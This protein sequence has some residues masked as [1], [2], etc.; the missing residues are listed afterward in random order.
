MDAE[1]LGDSIDANAL[2]HN[3]DSKIGGIRVGMNQAL[4]PD[5]AS[6]HPLVLS[7]EEDQP[8]CDPSVRLEP[9]QALTVMNGYESILISNQIKE[10]RKLII[11]RVNHGLVM[12]SKNAV[13][14]LRMDKCGNVDAVK[15]LDLLDNN[16]LFEK[17]EML[18]HGLALDKNYIY[19]ATTNNIYQFP[20]S[21]GQHSPLENGRKVV[22]NINPGNKDAMPDV[23][24]D[25]FGHAF[26]PRSGILNLEPESISK[27]DQSNAIIKKFN[28]RNI[29]ENGFEYEKDGLV[30]AYGTNS[31]GSMAFDAQARLWGI[32]LPFDTIQ[33]SD[34]G[35][36]ISQHGPAEEI[37]LYG[38]S[39]GHYGFPYCFT[40]Y[41]LSSYTAQSGG[42]GAQWAHPS[43][44]N[45]SVDMDEFCRQH[46]NNQQP[47]IPLSPGLKAAGLYFYMGTGCS[48]GNA[49]TLGTSVG[50]PCNWTD[51]PI[52]AYRG[53]TGRSEGHSVVHLPF[54]DLGHKP[55]W[56]KPAEVIL[57]QEQPCQS[58]G[59][60]TPVGVAVDDYGR[61]LVGSEETNEIYMVRRIFSN[62]AAQALTDIANKK[63]AIKEAAMEASEEETSGGSD[64]ASTETEADS[65]DADF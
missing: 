41:D 4:V 34:M 21:D 48:V 32:D 5:S 20:Y 45:G 44:S 23:A 42:L 59:C 33:R 40:E 25:P 51:T 24:I 19:I 36:D 28:F 27:M 30:F 2:S 43:Y 46:E 39:A 17:D 61:I 3:P 53:N 62:T 11:D 6:D 10:P 14:S 29:P 60:F 50:L 54:D 18:A 1:S 38:A 47:A 9:A 57:Q 56:D 49:Q 13:Y 7:H 52:V 8:L 58:E 16:T 63:E 31:H 15:I 37:N 26:I 55:R 64:E 35:G 22:T 65:S 12:S